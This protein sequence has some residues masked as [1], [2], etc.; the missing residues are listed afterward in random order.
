MPI[1][2]ALALHELVGFFRKI[3]PEF[4]MAIECE[5][6]FH[7]TARTRLEALANALVDEFVD[8][9]FRDLHDKFG[10]RRHHRH[11]LAVQLQRAGAEPS[12]DRKSTSMKYSHLGI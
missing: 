1:V 5:P 12:S 2:S 8:A 4:R 3:D 6:L 7:N 10:V 11:A 9:R